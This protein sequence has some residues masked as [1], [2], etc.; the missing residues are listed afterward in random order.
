MGSL[1]MIIASMA[2]R[3]IAGERPPTPS[4]H[5]YVP[6][7]YRVAGMNAALMFAAVAASA[8]VLAPSKFS[9]LAVDVEGLPSSPLPR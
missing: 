1:P 4:K 8:L 7:L 3:P 2:R 9:S 6:L 5:A